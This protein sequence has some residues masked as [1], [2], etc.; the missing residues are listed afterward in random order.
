M[1]PF[2][3]IGIVSW[4]S[5]ETAILGAKFSNNR[6]IKNEDAVKAGFVGLPAC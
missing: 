4:N 3:G 6:R 5:R 1:N 2:S